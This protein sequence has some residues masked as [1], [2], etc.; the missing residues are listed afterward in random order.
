MSDFMLRYLVAWLA[1]CALALVLFVKDVEVDWRAWWRALTVPW[2]LAVFVP[3]VFF[4]TFAGR[5][6]DDETWDVVTGGGMALLTWLTAGFSVGTVARALSGH[7]TYRRGSHLVVATALTVFSSSW[8]Y[9]VALLIRDGAFSHRW[10]GNLQLSP[11]VY[12]CAG[13]VLNLEV[14][15]RGRPTWAFLRSDWPC[16]RPGASWRLLAGLVPLVVVAG[17]VLVGFVGWRL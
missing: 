1:F 3:G 9:D 7:I 17:F 4:V 6:T 15:A 16:P 13:L 8:F 14:D 12:A 2:R 10:L 11:I 5:F